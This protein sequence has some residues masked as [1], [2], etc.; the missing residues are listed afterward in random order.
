MWEGGALK[1][2]DENRFYCKRFDHARIKEGQ[3]RA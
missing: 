3:A 1:G 2:L